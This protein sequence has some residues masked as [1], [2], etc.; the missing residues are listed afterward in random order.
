MCDKNRYSLNGTGLDTSKC[1]RVYSETNS[2][3]TDI[4]WSGWPPHGHWTPFSPKILTSFQQ[5]GRD[6][7]N[8]IAS[9]IKKDEVWDI[10]VCAEVWCLYR[11]LELGI[12]AK[13]IRISQAQGADGYLYQEPCKNCRQWLELAGYRTY[14][15]KDK[16]LPKSTQPSP[17]PS[18]ADFP[19]L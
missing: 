13:N 3:I 15:I 2:S 17:L 16:F 14:R 10:G 6:I 1:C 9:G 4:Q 7:L 19:A 11:G 8:N 12:D 5:P 18:P